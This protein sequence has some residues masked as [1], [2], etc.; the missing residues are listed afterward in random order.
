[1]FSL[2]EF[3]GERASRL[4]PDYGPAAMLSGIIALWTREEI[5]TLKVESIDPVTLVVT[6][7]TI[8]GQLAGTGDMYESSLHEGFFQGAPSTKLGR[9]AHF[10]QET[11]CEGT[12]GTWCRRLAAG[13]KL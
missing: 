12:S 10:R 11:N 5:G 4:H 7:C 1:L 9:P 13:T 2:S 8:C 3:L 6:D